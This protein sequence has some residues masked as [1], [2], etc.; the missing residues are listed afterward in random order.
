MSSVASLTAPFSA[1][2]HLHDSQREV[3]CPHVHSDAHGG[4][5]KRAVIK[6]VGRP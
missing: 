6:L 2:Q 5:A 3:V 1:G 4:L